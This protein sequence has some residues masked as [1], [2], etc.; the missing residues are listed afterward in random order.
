MK[1]SP[2]KEQITLATSILVTF[3]LM[4]VRAIN[5][6]KTGERLYII[7]QT[8]RGMYLTAIIK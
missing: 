4:Q 1:Q 3:S 7:E 2:K 8:L 6:V 5:V